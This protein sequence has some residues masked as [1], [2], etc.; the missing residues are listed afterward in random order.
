MIK[1]WAKVIIRALK[2]DNL[3]GKIYFLPL[4]F[5]MKNIA[6]KSEAIENIKK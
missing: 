5:L 1:I 6:K 2:I 4:I 3:S